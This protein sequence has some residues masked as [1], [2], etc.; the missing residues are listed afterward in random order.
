MNSLA[1]T[2]RK[3]TEDGSKVEWMKIQWISIRKSEPL[4]MFFKYTVQDDA[5][6]SCVSFKKKAFGQ[7]EFTDPLTQLYE[8]QPRALSQEKVK[9]AKKLLKY[10]PQVY[11]LWYCRL[12]ANTVDTAI[13]MY[14]DKLLGQSEDEANQEVRS[15]SD[16]VLPQHTVASEVFSVDFSVP[17]CRSQPRRKCRAQTV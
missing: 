13:H 11:H 2:V 3:T 16:E 9:D 5:V 14:E 1:V 15:V 8:Q 4:K 12:E 17:Y 7:T 6:F 10:V